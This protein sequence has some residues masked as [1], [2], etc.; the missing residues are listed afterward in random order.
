M[1]TQVL[2]N[3]LSNVIR[4]S[5]SAFSQIHKHMARGTMRLMRNFARTTFKNLRSWSK[6]EKRNV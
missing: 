3:I 4:K 6:S 5:Y 1:Q 2:D